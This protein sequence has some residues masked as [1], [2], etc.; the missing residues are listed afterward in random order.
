MKLL[1]EY[2]LNLLIE[3]VED[4]RIKNK[5]LELSKL[6][7]SRD[8]DPSLKTLN[9]YFF[10]QSKVKRSLFSFVSKKGLLEKAL[11]D[12]DLKDVYEAVQ[13]FTAG[14]V[15][16]VRDPSAFNKHLADDLNLSYTLLPSKKVLETQPDKY[17]DAVGYPLTPVKSD[18]ES[19]NTI[20]NVLASANY[21]SI[22]SRLQGSGVSL[23]GAN[24]SKLFRGM[25]LE[26]E[27]INKLNEGSTFDHGN[28]ASWTYDLNQALRFA[29]YGSYG[30]FQAVIFECENP[31]RGT[32]IEHISKYS[33][34]R[35]VISSGDVR[36]VHKSEE[37]IKGRSFKYLRVVQI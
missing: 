3:N 36:V 37:V 17:F 6:F 15:N 33:N 13:L 26:K 29:T 14:N 23:Q 27:V 24:T 5:F 18:Y 21:S 22:V 11:E 34:E 19:A 1:H 10:D 35:E 30:S 32:P 4:H 2:V 25:K 9:K 7:K 8:V 28:M 12:L 16:S 20:N 31:L